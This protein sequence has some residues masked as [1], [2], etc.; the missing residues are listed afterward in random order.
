MDDVNSSKVA[1]EPERREA[2]RPAGNHH[3]RP[4][5]PTLLDVLR[6]YVRYNQAAIEV[7]FRK[8]LAKGR[9]FGR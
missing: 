7:S 1:A 9:H 5:A 4:V 8:A 6:A 2:T 3:P